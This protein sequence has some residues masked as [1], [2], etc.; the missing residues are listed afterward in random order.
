MH[1][2]L[3]QD[4]IESIRSPRATSC[5][6]GERFECRGQLR[7]PATGRPDN[8][9]PPEI[10]NLLLP[11]SPLLAYLSTL[12]MAQAR[13]KQIASHLTGF[14]LS[15]RDAL[16]KQN[17]DDVVVCAAGASGPLDYL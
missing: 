3:Q 15:G 2:P 8:R 13:V 17:D 11:P 10:S 14:G 1:I 4:V 16:L 5:P 6:S 9:P 7:P 12:N